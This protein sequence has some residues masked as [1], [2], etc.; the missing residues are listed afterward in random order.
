[1]L[2]A[3]RI[4]EMKAIRAEINI[5]IQEA[6][7][8]E[9][10]ALLAIGA[11]GFTLLASANVTRGAA[12]EFLAVVPIAILVLGWLRTQHIASL[13]AKMDAYLSII[14]RQVDPLCVGEA[15]PLEERMGVR[16]GDKILGWVNFYHGRQMD[17]FFRYRYSIWGLIS[18][19]Y[20]IFIVFYFWAIF[21]GE[22]APMP[23][24]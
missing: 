4:E 24:P 2:E 5:Q 9:N 6:Y 13:I 23:G 14:E 8:L 11:I 12:K 18:A 10:F 19:S 15:G 22:P 1:M 20:G 16:K 17:S 21:A 3:Y 7:R